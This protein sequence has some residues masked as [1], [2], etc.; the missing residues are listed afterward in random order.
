MES[1][2]DNS[3]LKIG[4]I[5]LRVEGEPIGDK[6]EKLLWLTQNSKSPTVKVQVLRA[7]KVETLD[8]PLEDLT[9]HEELRENKYAIV[10]GL[11]IQDMTPSEHQVLA[12]GKPGII[13]TD[14]IPL[15]ISEQMTKIIP[16]SLIW[17][18]QIDGENFPTPNLDAFIKAISAVP[19]GKAIRLY[20]TIPLAADGKSL[21]VGDKPLMNHQPTLE[22]MTVD[23]VLTQENLSLTEMKKNFDFSEKNLDSRNWRTYVKNT[24]LNCSAA[25]QQ[26]LGKSG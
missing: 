2:H 14:S 12:Q 3:P 23:G 6:I 7:R 8:V 1:D 4:D 13:V 26:V 17:A 22:F 19:P 20:V 11:F 5:L 10:S 24:P 21:Q 16:G 25:L 15:S 18:I 9:K